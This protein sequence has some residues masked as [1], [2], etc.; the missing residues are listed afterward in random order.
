MTKN[1][2]S[3]NNNVFNIPSNYHFIKTLANWL[4]IHY[5]NDFS[6]L[7]IFLPNQRSSRKLRK[8]LATAENYEGKFFAKIKS[9]ADLNI[10]DFYDFLPSDLCQEIINEASQIKVLNRIDATFLICEEVKK[11]S[12]FGAQNFVQRYKIAKSLYQLFEDLEE[13]QIDNVQINLIDDSNLAKHHQFTV[14]FFQSFYIQIKNHLIRNNLMFA[15]SFHNFLCNKYIK[16]L[17]TQNI[18]QNIV[19]AGSTGSILS[20]KNLIKAIKNYQ[21]FNSLMT[22][23]NILK[24]DEQNYSLEYIFNKKNKMF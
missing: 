2:N 9:F 18:S 24:I 17:E 12:I 5:N 7:K 11:N 15:S 22:I 3:N 19:I 21:K 23:I 1:L 10:E 6:D 8:E 20:S 16:I 4:K 13:N 14:E